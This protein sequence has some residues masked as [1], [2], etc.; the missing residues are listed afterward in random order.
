MLA[1]QWQLG[2]FRGE[3]AAS[4][5]HARIR[6]RSHVMKTFVN[7]ATT[8]AAVEP[9][10]ADRPLECRVEAEAV[11]QG[12]AAIQLSVEAGLQ[13]IRR[14]EAAG[15]TALKPALR[16]A[17]PLSIDAATEMNLPARDQQRLA[18]FARRALDGRSLYAG[19]DA[20]VAAIDLPAGQRA[21]LRDVYAAWRTE[22]ESTFCEPGAG[23][24]TWTD[25]RFEYSFSAAASTND[26]EVVLAASEYNG[27]H[28]DWY[29]FDVD[30]EQ[31]HGLEAGSTAATTIDLLP[32]P[33]TYRGM[34]A[35]RWWEFE[36][37]TVYFGDLAA[38]PADLARL[39]MTEFAACYSD[40]WYILPLRL[41]VGALARISRL[42]IRDTFGGTHVVDSTALQDQRAYGD[43]RAWRFF[44]LTGDP[45]VAKDRNPW[46]LVA[47]SLVTSLNGSDVERVSMVR[48]EVANM[49]W[50]IE[51]SIETPTGHPFRRKQQWTTSQPETTA[52]TT[53]AW[54]YRLMTAVPP[55]WVPFVP[56][57]TADGASMRLRR[58]RHQAWSL[59][60]RALVGAQ[61]R[62]LAPQ[63]PLT[64][65]EE[66]IPQGGLQLTRAWQAARGADGALH[67]WMARRKRPGRGERG[68]GMKADVIET[69]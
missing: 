20:A 50:G 67:V 36:E 66:E 17:F 25:E 7:G 45:S 40:D 42:E 57:R 63:R 41:P 33:V 34:P 69:P 13:F 8:G 37:G 26:G 18:L 47:P 10:R 31:T 3:D 38:G 55:Y 28:L 54:R 52:E 22:Y 1:R 65:F 12:P 14:L 56:E 30:G 43:D 49:A 2:E 23:G 62:L 4:P 6:F 68:A 16:A 51:E 5:I 46:L 53:E 32:T 60:P 21:A 27:G 58:A 11:R 9:L 29:A 61:G 24:D 64:L 15:L 44:E 59:L 48:D 35:S 19:A 39:I